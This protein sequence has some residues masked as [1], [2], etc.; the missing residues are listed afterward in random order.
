[1]LA[2]ARASAARPEHNG[3]QQP[4]EGVRE[5]KYQTKE[6]GAEVRHRPDMRPW[7]LCALALTGGGARA[8]DVDEESY[9]S[10]ELSDITASVRLDAL[11]GTVAALGDFDSDQY[12]DLL[13]LSTNRD[14]LTVLRWDHESKRFIRG[15]TATAGVRGTL[16]VVATDFNRDGRLDVLL[17][18]ERP[19]DAVGAPL[20]RD[21]P[22][23]AP[24]G[25]GA[26]RAAVNEA[27]TAPPP[28]PP[29]P[30]NTPFLPLS[31]P[32]HCTHRA[33]ARKAQPG[34]GSMPAA[35]MR[36]RALAPSLAAACGGVRAGRPSTPPPTTCAPTC[37]PT[38]CAPTCAPTT[39]A[40]TCAPA[41]RTL[42]HRRRLAAAPRSSR[43][44]RTT[45]N[46]PCACS[47]GTFSA[48]TVATGCARA[49]ATPSASGRAAR[50][51][52]HAR[53]RART[54]H[55]QQSCPPSR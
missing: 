10:H 28:P 25:T 7:V 18:R 50:R 27:P 44:R 31:F 48:A 21:E 33:P 1:M 53:A 16:N 29:P 4:G 20:P 17:V 9:S 39:C 2:P 11:N 52:P 45:T 40:P 37:A 13:V 3:P 42:P 8:F 23:P 30:K 19:R 32:P 38:T 6:V 36:A 34:R 26:A 51:T 24:A 5:N 47:P 46:A 15:P 41:C 54:R 49:H 12:T 35:A 14:E 22:A 55:T 43:A